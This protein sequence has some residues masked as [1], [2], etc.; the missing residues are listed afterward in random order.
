MFIILRTN[1]SKDLD[2]KLRAIVSEDSGS[3]IKASQLGDKGMSNSRCGLV[4][5]CCKNNKPTE[6]VDTNKAVARALGAAWKL[7]E[8]KTSNVKVSCWK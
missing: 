7:Q 3:R 6:V 1:V 5:K 8:V 2:L 4:A